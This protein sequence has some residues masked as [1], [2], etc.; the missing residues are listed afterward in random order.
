MKKPKLSIVIPAYNEEGYLEK[1]LKSIK[2]QNYSDYETIVVCNGCSDKT[3]KI[4]RGY[5]TVLYIKKPDII[6]ARNIGA[7]KAKGEKIVFLDADTM[8]QDKNTLKEIYKSN[9]AIGT[10]FGRPDKNLFKYRVYFYM[11]N[12]A[13]LFG[14]V[15]N[16]TFCDKKVFHKVGGYTKDK[17]PKENHDLIKKMK[18][19]GK[20]E[21]LPIYV[22][23][24]MRRYEKFGFLAQGFYW[25]KKAIG[26]KEEYPQI[27]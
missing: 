13:V 15:N 27:N 25:F 12:I 5:S 14:M 23:T 3:E 9:A 8:M 19:Y 20:F 10:C 1:T 21:I 18:K 24:S 16:I 6:K 17:N 7:E 26:S 22:V 11:K 4:A 2:A